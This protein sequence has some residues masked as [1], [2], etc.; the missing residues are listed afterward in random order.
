MTGLKIREQR[1][2]KKMARINK[3]I[4]K[5]IQ[6]IIQDEIQLDYPVQR[7]L[8]CQH[9]FLHDWADNNHTTVLVHVGCIIRPYWISIIFS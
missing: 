3:W 8:I 6:K 9:C 7:R 1:A 4:G 5:R 2:T